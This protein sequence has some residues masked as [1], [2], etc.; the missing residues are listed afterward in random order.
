M[1]VVVVRAGDGAA[2]AVSVDHER[3]TYRARGRV[4]CPRPEAA[5]HAPAAA[6]RRRFPGARGARKFTFTA[7]DGRRSRAGAA[8]PGAGTEATSRRAGGP[9]GGQVAA[10]EGLPRIASTTGLRDVVP[11]AFGDSR[12]SERGG[13][14]PQAPLR[15]AR[16]AIR[17]GGAPGARPAKG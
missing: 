9:S 4:R 15:R 7:K 16:P 17:P 3:A 11:G 14:W 2:S 6:C 5:A 10:H 1:V 12:S 13:C 8:E